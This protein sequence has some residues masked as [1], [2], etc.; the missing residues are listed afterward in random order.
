M[1]PET[2]SRFTPSYVLWLHVTLFEFLM[3]PPIPTDLHTSSPWTLMGVI[4]RFFINI[5]E[6][7][8][9]YPSFHCYPYW[10]E[11][12]PW[13]NV[14]AIFALWTNYSTPV[15]SY[16]AVGE[17]NWQLTPLPQQLILFHGV[18]TDLRTQTPVSLPV[19]Y[20]AHATPWQRQASAP[21]EV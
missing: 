15:H 7:N 2:W 3:P 12:C 20:L 10:Y 9:N 1:L 6:K 17:V 13:S 16:N 18:E 21:P 14:I 5:K 8:I 11:I 4:S 19:C